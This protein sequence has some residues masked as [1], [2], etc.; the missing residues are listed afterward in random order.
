M[1]AGGDRAECGADSGGP[2]MIAAGQQYSP[3]KLVQVGV[4]SFGPKY[5]NYKV[6]NIYV[7]VSKYLRWIL[8][9]IEP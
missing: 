8:D 2:L 9:S 6:S 3:P 1:C 4:T 7:R 5:C